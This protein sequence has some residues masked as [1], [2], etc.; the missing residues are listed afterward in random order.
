M[1]FGDDIA[2]AIV[3]QEPVDTDVWKQFYKEQQS[4]SWNQ[5]TGNRTIQDGI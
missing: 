5:G 3:N 2:A 1:E 4:W